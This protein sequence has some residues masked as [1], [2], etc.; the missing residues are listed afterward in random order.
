METTI[1]VDTTIIE[2]ERNGKLDGQELRRIRGAALHAKQVYPGPV[3]DL[4]ARELHAYADLGYRF[5][6]NALMDRLA[7]EIL[8]IRSP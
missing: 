5:L 3:G 2:R 1:T 4:L 7:T 6:P 8:S